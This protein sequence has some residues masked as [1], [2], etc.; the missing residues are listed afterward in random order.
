MTKKVKIT[1]VL[2]TILVVGVTFFISKVIVGYGEVTINKTEE[3]MNQHQNWVNEVISNSDT[4][5]Y[6]T[7][8]RI[9]SLT[10]VDLKLKQKQ[11]SLLKLELKNNENQK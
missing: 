6:K 9:D 7:K 8:M 1:L 11:D 5:S 3:I 2:I 10:K 4:T